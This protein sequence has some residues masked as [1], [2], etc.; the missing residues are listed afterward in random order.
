MT[1][2]QSSDHVN[3]ISEATKKRCT[4]ERIDPQEIKRFVAISLELYHMFYEAKKIPCSLFFRVGDLMIEF[5][6]PREYSSELLQQLYNSVLK[7]SDDIGLYIQKKDKPVYHAFMDERREKKIQGLMTN[8]SNLDPKVL[9]LYSNI[10]SVSQM[11]VKGGINTQTAE[12]V[13]QTTAY[14]VDNALSSEATISTLSKM[15]VCDDTLYDHSATVAMLAVTIGTKMLDNP[16]EKKEAKALGLSGLYHDL[17][18][19]CIPSAILNKPGKFSAEEFEIMKTHAELGRQELQA[20]K[21]QKGIDLDDRVIRVASEH[22]ENYDGSGYPCGKCG[23]FEENP[24]LGIHPFTRIVSIADVYSALL[25]KRVYKDAYEA[26]EAI[27][28]MSE[29]THKF[30]PV[31]FSA[32]LKNVVDSLKHDAK[33]SNSGKLIIIDQGKVTVKKTG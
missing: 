3:R 13:A 24:E 16:V 4:I 15:I 28:I 8:V 6:K 21:D 31:Y 2:W 29:M 32:F 19:T 7:N 25:M 33:K 18:K 11:V 12:L 23:R 30:D 22:H 9:K 17:G 5:V 1:D 10:S 14:L 20:L 26:H 27:Q